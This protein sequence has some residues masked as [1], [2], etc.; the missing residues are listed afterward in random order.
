MKARQRFGLALLLVT[1][2]LAASAGAQPYTLTDLGR[3]P[4]NGDPAALGLNSVGAVCGVQTYGATFQAFV[5]E[6]GV[7][8]GLGAGTAFDINN[9]GGVVGWLSDS[10]APTGVWWHD[11]V[12]TPLGTLGGRYSAAR[13][14]NDVNQITGRAQDANN[15]YKAFLYDNGA[16]RSL[17]ALPNQYRSEGYDI[18]NDGV[19]VGWSDAGTSTRPVIWYA[20]DPNGV[21]PPP[22]PVP[23]A[24]FGQAFHVNNL[25]QIV[26]F[27]NASGRPTATLWSQGRQI[28]LDTLGGRTSGAEG[29][30]DSGQVVGLIRFADARAQRGFLWQDGVMTD[31]ST[32]L[33]PLSEWIIID[34]SSIDDAGQIAATGQYLGVQHAVLLTPAG[35]LL[36][37]PQ[38]GLA[39]VENT[40]TVNG[41]TAGG[42]VNLYWGFLPGST[43]VALC[44]DLTV[45]IQTPFV[46]QGTADNAGNVTFTVDVPP[47]ASGYTVFMQAVDLST[48]T[49]SKL[50]VHILP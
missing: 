20:P 26:G 28:G 39:G 25:G 3:L 35:V 32:L 48:C 27:A 19:V 10:S 49:P 15:D 2:T 29:I 17:G 34:A 18:R 22:V 11:G 33:P 31:L 9:S 46:V 50:V 12:R 13:A 23:G 14:I 8:T 36:L 24:G 30:N 43:P 37:G 5:W 7:M 47:E 42:A 40:L 44:P 6:A 21:Y 45:P 16:M 38:P 41:A 4:G 1:A